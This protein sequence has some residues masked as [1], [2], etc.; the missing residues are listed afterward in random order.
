MTRDRSG[1]DVVFSE[2]SQEILSDNR[3][4][5]RTPGVGCPVNETG[6]EVCRQDSADGREDHS[7]ESLYSEML[8]N[9]I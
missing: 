9:Q 1:V 3:Q 4:F 8:D 7:A 2:R 5:N 6:S